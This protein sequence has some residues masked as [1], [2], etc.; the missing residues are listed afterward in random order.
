MTQ[1]AAT[2]R[3]IQ[4]A[5]HSDEGIACKKVLLHGWD[6]DNIEPI[7]VNV[8][9]DGYMSTN[10]KM[11]GYTGSNFHYA[12]LD[13][14]SRSLQTIDQHD[15]DVHR[16]IR[17][18]AVY[19]AGSINTAATKYLMITT[20]NSDT[21]IHANFTASGNGIT[22]LELFEDPTVSVAGTGLTEFNVYRDSVATAATAV[23]THTPTSS[24]DGTLIDVG[25][26]T[27]STVTVSEKCWVLKA[28]EQYFAK[29]TSYS[30]SN[31]ITISVDWSEEESLAPS[32]SPS[33]SPSVSSSVSTSIS[34]SVSP[35]VSSSISTS[36]SLSI[37]PSV[38]TSI[39]PSVSPSI[40][41]SVSPSVSFSISPSVSP[42]V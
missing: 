36:V 25:T 42:S 32:A 20:P 31:V 14:M 7:K 6:T 30:D 13:P 3:E 24:G 17:F 22:K 19:N 21:L 28:N 29:V 18:H 10:S 23:V 38:S 16:G 2:E 15:A 5:E 26:G 39:S 9:S 12:R 27:G 37:S 8:D 41:P 11:Q 1:F 34:P 35:S 40:S 33:I 4:R